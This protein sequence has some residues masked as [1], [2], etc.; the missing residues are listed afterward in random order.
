MFKG[1]VKIYELVNGKET[2][3]VSDDNILTYGFRSQ[4]ASL[5]AGDGSLKTENFNV[6]LFQLGTSSLPFESH[7]PSSVFFSLSSTINESQYGLNSNFN[8]SKF[9]R[10]IGTSAGAEIRFSAEPTSGHTLAISNDSSVFAT[11]DPSNRTKHYFESFNVRIFLDKHTCDGIDIREAGLYFNNPFGYT[12][13]V[14]MLMAYKKF[15]TPLK[16]NSSNDIIID[17]SIGLLGTTN[18]VDTMFVDRERNEEQGALNPLSSVDT[19]TAELP[20]NASQYAPGGGCGEIVPGL[21]PTAITAPIGNYFGPGGGGSVPSWLQVGMFWFYPPPLNEPGVSFNEIRFGWRYVCNGYWQYVGTT[22]TVYQGP[23]GGSGGNNPL[24]P[25]PPQ[26]P[27]Y[28]PINNPIYYASGYLGFPVLLPGPPP[29]IALS[30]G[31]II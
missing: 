4:I 2:L 9:N 20:T 16:K 6:G 5:L 18:A 25:L 11:I 19:T 7:T 28:N 12:D 8:L 13:K 21:I 14:P 29:N 22:N 23:S 31:Y 15:S 24:I 26:I 3:L 27:L 30:G 10:I 1:H 17:W